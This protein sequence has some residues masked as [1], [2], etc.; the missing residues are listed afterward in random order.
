MDRGVTVM[1]GSFWLEALS[2]GRTLDQG[3]TEV[4]QAQEPDPVALGT[5]AAKTNGCDRSCRRTTPAARV[6]VACG[7]APRG[8]SPWARSRNPGSPCDEDGRSDPV[9][10]EVGAGISQM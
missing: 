9:M 10:R 8:R 7:R 3:T 1:G 2:S 5:H 6:T 4:A